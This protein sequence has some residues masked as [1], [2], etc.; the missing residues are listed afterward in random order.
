MAQ[1]LT[2]A[3]F[4]VGLT[5]P[6]SAFG[7]QNIFCVTIRGRCMQEGRDVVRP[8]TCSEERDKM[9]V[10]LSYD[11]GQSYSQRFENFTIT[12]SGGGF[13]RVRLAIRDKKPGSLAYASLALPA[14]KWEQV[15]H[16]IL[17]AKAGVEQPIEM[18]HEEPKPKG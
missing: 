14:E 1:T 10:N 5:L 9:N 11:S 6:P 13:K 4:P 17:A 16:A 3:T 8:K 2:P 7:R 18:S 12:V 15:A